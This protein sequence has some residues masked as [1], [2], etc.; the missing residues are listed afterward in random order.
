MWA[1]LEPIISINMSVSVGEAPPNEAPLSI[2]AM[3]TNSKSF[4]WLLLI[5]FWVSWAVSGMR[6]EWDLEKFRW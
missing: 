3:L 2:A 6:D 5:I 1:K 4:L